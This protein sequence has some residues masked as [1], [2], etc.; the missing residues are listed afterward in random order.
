MSE[1]VCYYSFNMQ[2]SGCSFKT[3]EYRCSFNKEMNHHSDDPLILLPI[4]KQHETL[5]KI[6][7]DFE[8]S[9]YLFCCVV[10]DLRNISANLFQFIVE[11]PNEQI[12][13]SIKEWY[14]QN[15]NQENYH[16]YLEYKWVSDVPL[17]Y[18]L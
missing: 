1:L 9:E 15:V 4:D 10:R 16:Y 14:A 8:G 7:K 12:F 2:K 6:K 18:L 3:I 11:C 5:S 13:T 17:N